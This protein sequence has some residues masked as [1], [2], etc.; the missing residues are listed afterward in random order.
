MDT[1]KTTPTSAA[2]RKALESP[3]TLHSVTSPPTTTTKMARVED[4]TEEYH[5]HDQHQAAYTE[6]D[7]QEFLALYEKTPFVTFLKECSKKYPRIWERVIADATS[8]RIHG[9][10]SPVFVTR[11]NTPIQACV[12]LVQSMIDSYI[13]QTQI[14]ANTASP[15]TPGSSKS[16]NSNKPQITLVIGSEIVG[17][18]LDDEID[19]FEQFFE[20][21]KTR[22]ALE[23]K[24]REIGSG[25]K[26][27]FEYHSNE[28]C[29]EYFITHLLAAINGINQDAYS[30]ENPKK[31]R[32]AKIGEFIRYM[33]RSY[34]EYLKVR[35]MSRLCNSIFSF[36]DTLTE[37]CPSINAIRPGV[38]SYRDIVEDMPTDWSYSVKENHPPGPLKGLVIMVGTT[39]KDWKFIA[40]NHLFKG[41][42]AGAPACTNLIVIEHDN[43]EKSPKPFYQS[44]LLKE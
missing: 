1:A 5:G 27:C 20:S 22:G 35:D 42:D 9:I 7:L 13:Q 8:Q 3:E 14:M 33:R 17:R 36:T 29:L 12:Y 41:E 31:L 4:R 21:E 18:K 15:A 40:E 26:T 24:E 16:S 25:K 39:P 11:K 23:R 38:D 19:K 44:C 32:L 34:P 37:K 10:K 43:P 30:S 2:K 6:R 28:R